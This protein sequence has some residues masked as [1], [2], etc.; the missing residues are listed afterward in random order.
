[1]RINNPI[2]YITMKPNKLTHFIVTTVVGT[3][4]LC[5]CTQPADELSLWYE[6]PANE[7]MQAIPIGNGRLGAM[8]YGG[9]EEETIA[10]NEITLWSGQPDSTQNDL[11]GPEN[12]KKIRELFFQGKIEEGNHLG[13]QHLSGKGKSFG[14]HLPLGDLKIKF[15]Y[16]TETTEEYTRRLNLNES[17]ST[18]SFKKGNT[19]YSR[20]YFCSHPDE[21][22]AMRFT[23]D[24]PGKI[25]T[26]LSL[27]LLRQGTSVASK[28]GLVTAGI[29]LFPNLG[30]GGVSFN[31]TFNVYPNGGE[32][33]VSD[34]TLTIKGANELVILADIRTNYQ[35][36]DYPQIC[37]ENLQ[38]AAN[39]GYQSLKQRHIE[40]YKSLF[41]RMKISL[42][43]PTEDI[44][45][46]K[47]WANVKSGKEDVSLD[48]LFY[49]YG[50]YMLISSSR[51]GCPLPANL[52]GIWNDNLACNMP[53][54]CDYHLDINIQQ[55]YWSANVANLP[56]CNL[57]LFDYIGQ[58]AKAGHETARKV[59]GC[60]GWVA[61]TVTNA[62]GYT[63]PGGGVGWG[64][65]VTAGAW[66][67][68]HLWNHYLYTKDTDYLRT[69]GY[70]LLKKT[71]EFFV[72]Y[73]VEDPN[74]G[75]LV[76]G[77]SISPENSFRYNNGDWCMSM[78]PTID[79]AIV[80]DIYQACIASAEIL[81]VDADFKERLERDIKKLPPLMIGKSGKVQEWL[82]DVERSD[83]SH[84]HS[85]H[86][87]ALYPLGQ[88]SYT[89]TPELMAASRK[90]IESQ[91]NAP[92]WEDT[93]WSRANMINFFAR[94]KDGAKAYESLLGL[95]RVF[96]RENLMTV[97]P[98]GIAGAESDIFSFDANE[99]AVSGM[100]EMLLQSYDGFIEFLPAIPDSW[101]KGEVKGICAQ[102]G[103]VINMKWAQ[104]R[105]SNAE[106]KATREHVFRVYLPEK[107]GVPVL[108]INGKKI[109][110]NT[111]KELYD[112]TLSNGD[113]LSITYR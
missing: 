11:C 40:D 90:S 33:I 92:G 6:Q 88:I 70:P 42:G 82:M 72:D 80:Y 93:E 113:V 38:A 89:Q 4:T 16:D 3:G 51:P 14:T 81:N 46:D 34:S 5:C 73:M 37:F 53:W 19:R 32:I 86:L 36:E 50:R 27:D 17:V 98:A 76:T 8:I 69:T 59:Y 71:A 83:P 10:L 65:N 78:M 105:L 48:A 20:E 15:E 23:A 75:Y 43:T 1:M 12:L 54:T 7:W 13:T 108:E 55:N 63:A 103:L 60:N 30:P 102:G 68:T 49:Q 74:T 26:T 91:L 18:V 111:D 101:D 97:S 67:A 106:I 56:E 95:Y 25:T 64:L 107:W 2:K 94:M 57:P 44:A 109:D 9:I 28:K 79:R 58:L 96:S 99:A 21:V 47:R 41:D 62:W 52:Q 29:A 66:I 84:R 100:S 77:P 112:I 24:Q 31:G 87:V 39:T 61:H 104:K 45:T 35:T 85:S 110:A 22:I